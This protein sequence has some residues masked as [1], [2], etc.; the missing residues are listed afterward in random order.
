MMM[1][2]MMMIH[3]GDDDNG[4][5]DQDVIGT[6]YLSTTICRTRQCSRC[7]EAILNEASIDLTASG[8]IA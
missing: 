6:E 4:D 1:M 3:V 8:P 7:T 2:M 5:D